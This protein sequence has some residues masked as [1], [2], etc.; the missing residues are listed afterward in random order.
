MYAKRTHI[1]SAEGFHQL[2]SEIEVDSLFLKVKRQ[3]IFGIVL[4]CINVLFLSNEKNVNLL[5]VDIYTCNKI[6]QILC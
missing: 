1:I 3:N 5:N 2:S 6:S 4:L